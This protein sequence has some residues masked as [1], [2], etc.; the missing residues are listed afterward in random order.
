VDRIFLGLDRDV[1]GSCENGYE[2][3]GSVKLQTLLLHKLTFPLGHSQSV[4][5][6]G[7]W[8]AKLFHSTS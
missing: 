8:P 3:S 4:S 2:S 6:P 1:T 5:Q 7:I